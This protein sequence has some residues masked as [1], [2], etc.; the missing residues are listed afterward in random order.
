MSAVVKGATLVRAGSGE[1]KSQKVVKRASPKPVKNQNHM[2]DLHRPVARSACSLE[3]QTDIRDSANCDFET[4]W[5]TYPHRGEH[6]DPKKPARLEFE[7]AIGRGTDPADI[8]RGVENYAA[9]VAAN[10]S[11]PRYVPQAVTGLIESNGPS[12][13]TRPSRRGSG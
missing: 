9:Y 7:A 1:A 13:K 11:E 3:R 12:S 2:V 6:P 4:F 5:R 10:V 8:I